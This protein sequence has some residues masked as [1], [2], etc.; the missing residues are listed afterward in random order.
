MANQKRNGQT[1]TAR[2]QA[3]LVVDLFLDVLLSRDQDAGW[4]GDSLIGKLVDFKGELP[5][6]SGFSGFSKV[7]EQSKWLREWSDSHKMA[8]VVM[9][10]ISDRQ[11]EALCMDRAYRGRTKVA[12]D[13]FTPDARIEIHW[14]DEA[15]AQQLRCSPQAF[16]QRVHDGY[17]ALESLLAEKVAA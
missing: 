7:Y 5:K 11:R 9:R 10:N 2:Q 6:S 3:Q 1:R 17:R 15:C 4:Q 16:S 8:C 14:N 13:P 12:V